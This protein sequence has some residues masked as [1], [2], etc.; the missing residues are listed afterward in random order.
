MKALVLL[1]YSHVLLT[2]NLFIFP[3]KFFLCPIDEVIKLVINVFFSLQRVSA[4]THLWVVSS[5]EG[6]VRFGSMWCITF[7]TIRKIS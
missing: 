2:D 4:R 7:D 5:Q 3:V 6:R 1:S